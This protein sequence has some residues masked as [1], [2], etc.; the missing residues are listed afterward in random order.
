MLE[1]GLTGGVCTRVLAKV[2][3]LIRW[4]TGRVVPRLWPEPGELGAPPHPTLSPL[5]LQVVNVTGNQDICYYNFL[6][7]HPLGNL[8]WESSCETPFSRLS[9][10]RCKV[11]R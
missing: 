11:S 9:V 10:N 5:P 8:R 4:R 2:A 3:P 1:V 7:A 6:C